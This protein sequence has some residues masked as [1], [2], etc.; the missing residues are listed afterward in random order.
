[1]STALDA[2]LDRAAA[3]RSPIAYPADEAGFLAAGAWALL[4]QRSALGAILADVPDRMSMIGAVNASLGFHGL[5]EEG[6]E[7]MEEGRSI[8]SPRIA[9]AVSRALGVP[10]AR[11][12]PH[13]EAMP[14]LGGVFRPSF[15]GRG[16]MSIA[17]HFDGVPLLAMSMVDVVP[18]DE[19]VPSS[20]VAPPSHGAQAQSGIRNILDRIAERV[21]SRASEMDRDDAQEE[22]DGGSADDAGAKA[23]IDPV[24]DA[25]PAGSV[26]MSMT[27]VLEGVRFVYR[28]AMS[29]ER[30]D[31]VEQ[32]LGSRDRAFGPP[33]RMRVEEMADG[34]VLLAC[35]LVVDADLGPALLSALG[36]RMERRRGLLAR[37]L[38]R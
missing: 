22:E 5:D 34:R 24:L 35:D 8:M 27:A 23:T 1:M 3:L 37:L 15:A 6:L 28:G 26:L 7:A 13:V 14:W 12:L 21:A 33:D 38:G 10:I 30:L 19:S 20:E 18:E 32:V 31:A 25:R 36:R 9:L 29:R 17:Q 2:E 11:I 16:W 4:R